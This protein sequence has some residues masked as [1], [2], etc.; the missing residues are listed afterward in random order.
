MVGKAPI[1][2]PTRGRPS[3]VHIHKNKSIKKKKLLGH[4]IGTN[5]KH[6]AVYC[7]R[8]RVLEEAHLFAPLLKGTQGILWLGF[9][10]N[11]RCDRRCVHHRAAL[12][13]TVNRG[14]DLRGLAVGA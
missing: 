14:R 13:P 9:A 10:C 3:L 8:E 4:S 2:R 12:D 1:A 7:R 6:S 11:V 5:E